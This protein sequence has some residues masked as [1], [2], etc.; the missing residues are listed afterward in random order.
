MP[1]TYLVVGACCEISGSTHHGIIF[2]DRRCQAEASQ[3]TI[4]GIAPRAEPTDDMD[5]SYCY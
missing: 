2:A 4:S 1:E 5:V 3:R